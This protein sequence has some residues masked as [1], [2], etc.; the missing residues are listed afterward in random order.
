MD[1]R[2][3]PRRLN[4]LDLVALFAGCAG[5]LAIG[6]YFVASGAHR[7]YNLGLSL[8]LTC[9]ALR[10][11]RPRPP[12]RLLARQP[13]FVAGLAVMAT[14]MVRVPEILLIYGGSGF[15]SLAVRQA[16]FATV[17]SPGGY[18]W[19]VLVSWSTLRLS[20]GWAAEAGLID[21]LGRAL[22][23]GWAATYAALPVAHWWVQ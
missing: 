18:G 1:A 16:L 2:D 15:D 7:H 4:L 19:P 13:G 8:T 10:A 3:V 14:V 21:R 22:G 9:L 11:R 20:G 12:W 6:R 23:W 17:L 5:G